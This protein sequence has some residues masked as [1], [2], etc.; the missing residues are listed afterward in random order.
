VH[1]AKDDYNSARALLRKLGENKSDE[2]L[3]EKMQKLLLIV[4]NLSKDRQRADDQ[5]ILGDGRVLRDGVFILP[6]DPLS[7]L[8]A[9]LRKPTAGEAQVQGI[10]TRVECDEKGIVFFVQVPE[11]VFRLTTNSF[12]Q[13]SLR[14][15]SPD[16]GRE[17]TCGTRKDENN[18]VVIY[19]PDETPSRTNGIAKSIEF[20][21]KDF[22]L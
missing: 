18:V 22:K 13:V 2:V 7:A 16:S 14:S 8:R 12:K 5:T 21:P 19:V 9:S 6:F 4:E 1:I 3:H 17:I 15:F 11:R 20:V 10:L